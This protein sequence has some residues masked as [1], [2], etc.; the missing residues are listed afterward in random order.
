MNNQNSLVLPHLAF[1]L[2]LRSGIFRPLIIRES[3]RQGKNS[4]EVVKNALCEI[5]LQ[6]LKKCK[7]EMM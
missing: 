1:L 4:S 7:H 2:F 5:L 6:I 3:T